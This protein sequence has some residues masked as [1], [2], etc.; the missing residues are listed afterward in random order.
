MF[1]INPVRKTNAIVDVNYERSE[2]GKINKEQKAGR[3]EGYFK[4]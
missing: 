1:G 2:S 4:I 3:K